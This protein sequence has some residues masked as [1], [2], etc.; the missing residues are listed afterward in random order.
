MN[1]ANIKYN[2]ISNGEGVRTSLFV[3]GCTHDCPGCFNKIAQSFD[4]GNPF[5]NSVINDIL[6]SLKPSYIK[7]LTILGGEPLSPKN[8]SEVLRLIK[9]VRKTFKDKDIWVYSGYYI[10][11]LLEMHNNGNPYIMEILQNTDI[12]VDGR[13]EL[14]LKD[15]SLKFR[16]SSNQSIINLKDYFK[17]LK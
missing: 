6:E 2:D 9:E 12:L 17:N 13:F 1:Y 10:K 3:S 11:E 4:Y 8:Q 7:G 5:D 15:I 16:G 14:S